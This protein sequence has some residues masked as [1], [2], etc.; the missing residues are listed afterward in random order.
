MAADG[1]NPATFKNPNHVPA[2]P[3]L[4]AVDQFDADF[5][6]ISPRQAELTDPQQRPF[7]GVRLGSV[8]KVPVVIRL[9]LM[10][11]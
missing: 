8:G 4:Q 10:A 9:R 3:V 11:P 1:I 6:D 7:F 5:F 2:G